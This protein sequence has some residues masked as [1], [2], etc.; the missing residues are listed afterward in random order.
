VVDADDRVGRERT[1][2]FGQG[3]VD[4]LEVAVRKRLILEV[5]VGAAYQRGVLH[6]GVVGVVQGQ[7]DQAHGVAVVEQ[8]FGEV[9]GPEA[10]PAEAADVLVEQG[11]QTDH[12]KFSHSFLHVARGG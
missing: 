11:S 4:E 1:G 7:R 2:Q 5:A 9:P 10:L 3:P 6:V 8:R 12:K